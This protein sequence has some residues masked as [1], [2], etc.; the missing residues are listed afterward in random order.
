ML[1]FGLKSFKAEMFF[2]SRGKLTKLNVTEW[3]TFCFRYLFIYCLTLG[4]FGVVQFWAFVD[5][6]EFDS[7]QTRGPRR[8][9]FYHKFQ[10]YFKNIFTYIHIISLAPLCQSA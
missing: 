2:A 10:F 9:L 4:C 6:L 7:T 8:S 5:L 1:I 3:F